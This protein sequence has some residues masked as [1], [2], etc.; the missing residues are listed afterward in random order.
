MYTATV[1]TADT[2]ALF[3]TINSCSEPVICTYNNETFDLRRNAAVQTTILLTNKGQDAIELTVHT[4][5]TQDTMKLLHF[6]ISG[7]HRVQPAAAKTALENAALAVRRLF[8]RRAA[9]KIT[10]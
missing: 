3:R 9:R 6:M 4:R 8:S 1:K 5:N 7:E 10:A 2:A